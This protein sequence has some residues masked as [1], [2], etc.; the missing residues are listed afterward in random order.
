MECTPW[1]QFGTSLRYFT[2]CVPESALGDI[3]NI[4][5]SQGARK[6]GKFSGCKSSSPPPP[7][8]V[9]VC[10]IRG[11]LRECPHELRFPAALLQ[12]TECVQSSVNIILVWVTFFDMGG[13]FL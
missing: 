8:V 7:G 11:L 6:E 13:T 10:C 2:V 12:S 3:T 9:T 4:S 5:C 1:R